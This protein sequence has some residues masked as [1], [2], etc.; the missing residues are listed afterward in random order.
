MNIVGGSVTLTAA[1]ALSISAG[2]AA[3]SKQK[4]ITCPFLKQGRV[5]F[6]VPA[7]PGAMPKEIDF[8]YP[9]TATQ[10]SFRD[11]KLS[12]IA[13]KGESSRVRIV[14]SAQLKNRDFGPA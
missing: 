8:D 13:M 3:S 6:D 4:V 5:T 2:T 1:L 9:A 10:F 12:L 14:I 7:K 11:G